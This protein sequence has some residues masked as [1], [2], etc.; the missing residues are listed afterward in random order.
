M[1]SR[2]WGRGHLAS[3]VQA[4]PGKIGFWGS[5]FMPEKEKDTY[6]RGISTRMY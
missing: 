2:L 3:K 5:F 1:L 4:G 6:E